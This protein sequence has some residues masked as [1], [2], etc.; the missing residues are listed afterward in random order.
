MRSASGLAKL[1]RSFSPLSPPKSI[2]MK[3]FTYLKQNRYELIAMLTGASVLMLEISGARLLSP[4]FG[5]SI[6][7]WTAM[8]GVILAS[9]SFGYWYGGK[10]ADKD[11]PSRDLSLLISAS[12]V[13]I[14]CIALFQRPVLDLVSND[15]L[16]LRLNAV[17][18]ALFLFSI[19]SA[20]IG[21][22]FPHLA[23]IKIK[24]LKTSGENVGRLEAASAIGSIAG[25]FL[26]GYFL[27]AYFGSRDL[28]LFLA[29]MLFATSFLADV[30]RYVA[31]RL[32]GILVCIGLLFIDTS[33]QNIVYDRD[34][35][36]VRYQVELA[37]YRGERTH[38][39]K[40]DGRGVQSAYSLDN[41]DKYVLDYAAKI[42]EILEVSEFENVLVIGGGAHTL[43]TYIHKAY[44]NVEITVA[45]IDP[46]LD[47]IAKDYFGYIEND[48][49]NIVY[50]DGRVFLN[51]NQ[52]EFD[53][54]IVDAYS[55][56][57]PPFQL[58][59]LE[60][61]QLMSDSL[62]S[63]GLVIANIVSLSDKKM[64]SSLDKTYREAFE[65][66]LVLQANDSLPLNV[67]Q[68]FILLAGSAEQAVKTQYRVQ[69]FTAPD[70]GFVLTD[71]YAPVERLNY[72]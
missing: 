33:P 2:F 3:I 70:V 62:S 32:I 53:I 28:T 21:M 8:I 63:D 15:A 48:K 23:K 46:A 67:D 22:V 14:A 72:R 65:D 57:T 11:R 13:L 34:S 17:I 4:Y 12:A 60:A 56:L 71:D 10:L 40:M 45:E 52:K 64:L 31:V 19:P 16:D 55:F 20:L 30:D 43:P 1:H 9:L 42:M 18:A 24:S 7:V 38:L 61:A 66:T 69:E 59:S 27:L 25:T 44:P 68:N 58:S 36:Y 37:D 54:I 39:L 29:I 49:T 6:Y 51:N 50:E 26:A 5:S 41:P 47:D 35:S